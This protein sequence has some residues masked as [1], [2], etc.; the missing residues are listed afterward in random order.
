MNGR[1]RKLMNDLHLWLGLASGL[2]L[3]VV[4][5][6]GTI[7]AFRTEIDEFFNKEKY[8]FE[9]PAGV[10]K[11]HTDSLVAMVAKSEKAIVTGLSI[12]AKGNR[13]WVFSI[14]PLEKAKGEER[15]KQVFVNPYTG[16]VQS[17]TETGS[18]KFFLTMMKLHRWLLMDMKT[19]RII[20]G[21]ATLIFVFLLLSGIILWLPKRF[22]YWKQCFTIMF[23]GKWKRL[24]H[25]L[26]N[27]LGF[28]SFLFLLIMSLTGLCWSFDWYKMGASKLLKAPVLQRGGGKPVMSS[29]S[30]GQTVAFS[31]VIEAANNELPK[32]GNIRVSAPEDSLGVFTVTKNNEAAFNVTATNKVSIDQYSGNVLKTEKFADKAFG[33]KIAASIKPLHTGEIFG[34]FSK[35]LYFI[36][37]LIGTCLPITGTFIWINKLRKQKVIQE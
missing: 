15:G 11:L 20:V 33:A 16:T 35:I 29:T 10:S 21:I 37:C 14:K 9:I 4:C 36:F 1:F 18:G 24:N 2:I 8:Y 27:V 6:S 12:P 13:V 22:R 34:L 31:S 23:S 19:G 7:Y 17:D 26:H 28:Y 32:R 30:S 25:D 5:L 3:F